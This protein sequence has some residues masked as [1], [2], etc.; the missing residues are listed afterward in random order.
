M[1]GGKAS[2]RER[3]ERYPAGRLGQRSS[4]SVQEEKREHTARIA[5][6]IFLLAPHAP[7]KEIFASGVVYCLPFPIS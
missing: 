2:I 3:M 1:S 7:T 5:A 6:S 4:H